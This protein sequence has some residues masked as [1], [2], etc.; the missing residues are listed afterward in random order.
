MS[1]PTNDDDDDGLVEANTN[2]GTT[3]GIGAG[4]L[5]E[6]TDGAPGSRFCT[7]HSGRLRSVVHGE[8]SR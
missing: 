8:E 1:A 7:W 2:H 5:T 3:R 6:N 4:K